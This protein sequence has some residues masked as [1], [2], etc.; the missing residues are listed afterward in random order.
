MRGDVALRGGFEG[1]G[2]RGEEGAPRPQATPTSPGP[3]ATPTSW[4]PTTWARPLLLLAL[5]ELLATVTH[6]VAALPSQL[7]RL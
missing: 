6:V 2:K 1:E 4:P 7:G 3:Q 5:L